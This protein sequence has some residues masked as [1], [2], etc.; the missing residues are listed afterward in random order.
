MRPPVVD[1]R[2][3]RLRKLNSQEFSHLKLLFGWV[4]YFTLYFLTESNAFFQQSGNSEGL[5]FRD[6]A[7]SIGKE[8]Q[9]CIDQVLKDM[10]GR[11]EADGSIFASRSDCKGHIQGICDLSHISVG[12][13]IRKGKT[14]FVSCECDIFH[15]GSH[16]GDD[17]FQLMDPVFIEASSTACGG[18]EDRLHCLKFSGEKFIAEPQSGRG[19][20]ISFDPSII[21]TYS[22]VP[23]S[24]I[25]IDEASLLWSNRDFKKMDKRIIEWFQLQRKYKVTVHLFSV[26]FDIDKKIR[27]LCDEMYICNKIGRVWSIARHVVRKPVIVHPVGDS[28]STILLMTK[29]CCTSMTLTISF[30][31]FLTAALSTSVICWTKALL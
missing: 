28:P 22:F 8:I 4:G 6:S 19:E 31:R 23:N 5:F 13:F 30:N 18:E 9:H 26:S 1:Y 14:F 12:E 25:Y 3:F 10:G 16:N 2:N 11:G 24:V 21:Y 29:A 17:H 20:T 7:F 27:D 15:I